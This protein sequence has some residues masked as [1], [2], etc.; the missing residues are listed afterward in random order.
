LEAMLA[1]ALFT[2]AVLGLLQ[3]LNLASL[4]AHEAAEKTEINRY[5][6]SIILTETKKAEFEADSKTYEDLI[7]GV[8]FKSSL[9]ELDLEAESGNS[10]R[11]MYQF[12]VTAERELPN[13]STDDLGSAEM[14]VYGGLSLVR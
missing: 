7:P 13:G 6:R 2:F 14:I 10:L 4:A 9:E 11:E 1:T 5:L 8:V 3:A 12:R